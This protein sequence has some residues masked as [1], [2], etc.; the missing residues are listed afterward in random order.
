M[1]ATQHANRAQER[2]VSGTRKYEAGKTYRERE[3]RPVFS[4]GLPEAEYGFV[5]R[6]GSQFYV[7]VPMTSDGNH[8]TGASTVD[9][10]RT[11]LYRNGVLVGETATPVGSFSGVPLAQGDFRAEV[12]LDRSSQF[13]FS[14]KVSAAWTFKSQGIEG[15]VTVPPLSVV[16]FEPKLDANG[17]VPAGT[18]QRI[19]LLTQSQGDTGRVRVTG[20]QY[21]HDDGK[22]WRRAG[23]VGKSAL[24]YN[25]TNAQWTS[26]KA[27]ATDAKGNTVELTVIRA[28]K[29]SS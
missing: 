25:P 13:E 10:G 23:V 6:F 9:S 28:Y 15:K 21:S 12:S 19:G 24:V 1:V 3:V 16:R 2:I 27:T 17:A 11:A 4:P 5:E 8:G 14:T 18:L 26:L 22:T 29:V 7:N 20:V